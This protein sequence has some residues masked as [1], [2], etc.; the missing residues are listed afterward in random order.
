MSIPLL[1]PLARRPGLPISSEPTQRD[2]AFFN[3]LG[4]FSHDGREYVMILAPG[5]TTPAP[6]V[7]VIANPQF[8]TV[9]SEGGSAYTWA[10]N[11]HEYRL[12]PWHNDSV[13]DQSGEA[14]Y[15]AMKKRDGS[16]PLRRC[17]PAGETHISHDTDLAIAFS[18]TQK[19]A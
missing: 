12:T 4:G 9:I 7:N 19:K 17:R 3:G 11:S 1:K 16:G 2:L 13:S 8:G 14:L 18:I 5:Q 10:E 6:W 15:L